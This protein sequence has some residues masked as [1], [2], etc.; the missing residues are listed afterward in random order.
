[1]T[2]AAKLECIKKLHYIAER[3]RLS[4]VNDKVKLKFYGK[5]LDLLEEILTA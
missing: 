2:E 3:M 5:I 4:A 1:M